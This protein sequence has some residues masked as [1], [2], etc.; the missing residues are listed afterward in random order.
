MAIK[1]EVKQADSADVFQDMVRVHHSYRP[2][3][4]AGRICCVQANGE[5]IRATARNTTANETG[6]IY[7]D[8]VMRKK[9]RVKDGESAE[10]TI[11]KGSVWD[12][13]VWA[14][15]ASDPVSRIGSRLAVL[16]VCLGLLG[17]ALGV[18]SIWLSVR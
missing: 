2:K 7:L 10:F 12:E 1:L 14:W 17:F 15:T 13:F 16:S 5:K 3:I 18:I 9:L 4:A 6:V 8:N 11:S